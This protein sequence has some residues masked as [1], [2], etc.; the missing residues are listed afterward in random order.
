MYEVLCVYQ[1]SI[2]FQGFSLL[3]N[4]QSQSEILYQKLSYQYYSLDWISLK[5]RLALGKHVLCI[6]L[7]ASDKQAMSAG[8]RMSIC[9]HAS[10][11]T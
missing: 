5:M 4:L 3:A 1:T 9:A 8:M 7:S 6:Y 10:P 2:L 11:L